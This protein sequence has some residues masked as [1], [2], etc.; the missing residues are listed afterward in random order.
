ML[1]VY[2]VICRRRSRGRLCGGIFHLLY[3]FRNRDHAPIV[4]LLPR[5]C[6]GTNPLPPVDILSSRVL[7]SSSPKSSM[8]AALFF[9][10]LR[11]RTQKT[12]KQNYVVM[13]RVIA[14]RSGVSL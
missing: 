5:Y 7:I 6:D 12:N 1:Y 9:R 14:A 2:F 11:E 3:S 13:L 8:S 10:R 4:T